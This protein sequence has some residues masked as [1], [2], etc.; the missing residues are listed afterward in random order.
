MTPRVFCDAYA[1]FLRELETASV[2]VFKYE[3]FLNNPEDQLR[4][5]CVKLG[6]RFTPSFRSTFHQLAPLPAI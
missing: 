5:M 6:L 2:T 4:A 1:A 3:E